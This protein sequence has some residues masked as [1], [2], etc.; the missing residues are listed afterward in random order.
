MHPCEDVVSD[1]HTISFCFNMVG[2]VIGNWYTRSNLMILSTILH[3][4]LL[5]IK[6]NLLY[7]FF[8]Q[9]WFIVQKEMGKCP[10][11]LVF[12]LI[13][14]MN[15][16]HAVCR[17]LSVHIYDLGIFFSWEYQAKLKIQGR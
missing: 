1:Y 2:V 12:T 9:S 8:Y 15:Y 4:P 3:K 14:R 13:T 10:R 16:V 11:H 7:Y 17:Y 6:D 5:Q